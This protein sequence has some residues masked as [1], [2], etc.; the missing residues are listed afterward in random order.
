MG[1]CDKELREALCVI[2][3][4]VL[5]D[6]LWTYEED[7]GND[8][9]SE[10]YDIFSNVEEFNQKIMDGTIIMPKDLDDDT[11]GSLIDIL[12]YHIKVREEDLEGGDDEQIEY[13]E[14]AIPKLRTMHKKLDDYWVCINNL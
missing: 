11:V 7:F 9:S 6:A 3:E 13:A 4:D 5:E 2:D 12:N 14:E 1:L 10:E 8:E